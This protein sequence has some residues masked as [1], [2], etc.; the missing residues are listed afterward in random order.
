RDLLSSNGNCF[1][2]RTASDIIQEHRP[3]RLS[4]VASGPLFGVQFSSLPCTDIKNNPPLPLGLAG[5]PGGM[6]LY[7]NGSLVGGIGVEADGVYSIDRNAF[8]IDIPVEEL[9]AVAGL[10]GF[11]APSGVRSDQ[12]LVYGVRLAYSTEGQRPSSLT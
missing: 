6:P 2:T 4:F 12:I 10:R 8:D 1:P 11:E 7:K 5:D 3:V 9:I